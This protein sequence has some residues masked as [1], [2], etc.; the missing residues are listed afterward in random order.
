MA[1]ERGLHRTSAE[2]LSMKKK[3]GVNLLFASMLFCFAL[4]LSRRAAAGENPRIGFLM[5]AFFR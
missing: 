5:P 4:P 2:Q 3:I 1:E